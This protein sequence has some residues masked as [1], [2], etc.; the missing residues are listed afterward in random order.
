ML[1]KVIEAEGRS[2]TYAAESRADEADSANEEASEAREEVTLSA[3]E[4]TLETK[5]EAALAADEVMLA[6]PVAPELAL[7]LSEAV[8][9]ATAEVRMGSAAGVPEAVAAMPAQRA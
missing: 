4:T 8:M 1:V 7:A 9:L 6:T 5:L 2:K 3:P